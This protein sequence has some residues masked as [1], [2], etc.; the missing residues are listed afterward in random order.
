VAVALE[1]PVLV[2]QVATSIRDDIL[3]GRLRPGQ[4]IMVAA[5]AKELGVSHIPVREA[6]RR[7]EAE[8][9]I[10]TVPRRSTVVAE[11]R[12]EELHEIY[13]LRRLIEG[14]TV[15]RA[16]PAYSSEDLVTIDEA[17]QRLGKADP[18]DLGSDF[19][20]AHQAF[21]WA[22]LAPA[23]DPWR[24]R[25]LGQLWQSSE[26]YHRL[27]TLVFGSLADAQAEHRHLAEAA[28]LGDPQEMNQLLTAHLHRTENTVVAGFVASLERRGKDAASGGP[29]GGA[30]S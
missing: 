30:A 23:I 8:S 22:V 2:D 1:R 4:R 18:R 13:D 15:M 5:L 28:H 25:M 9:L 7:L 21:H 6:I 11:V 10:T 19:W 24:K 17:M 16:A 3:S 27:F 14:D 26:R 20:A 29:P 12:L